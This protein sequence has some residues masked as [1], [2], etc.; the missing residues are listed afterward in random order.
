MFGMNEF[1]QYSEE[2]HTNIIH[3]ILSF[4]KSNV[5]KGMSLCVA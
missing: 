2:P 5:E 1:I 4:Y 3:K